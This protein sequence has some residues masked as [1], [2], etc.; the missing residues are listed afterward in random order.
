VALFYGWYTGS[1]KQDAA[2][3]TVSPPLRYAL[4]SSMTVDKLL[5]FIITMAL[6][7]YFFVALPRRAKRKYETI[8]RQNMDTLYTHLEVE[9]EEYQFFGRGHPYVWTKFPREEAE[10]IVVRS[11]RID[12]YPGAPFTLYGD[13]QQCLCVRN[14]LKH[15]YVVPRGESDTSS[16]LLHYQEWLDSHKEVSEN[17]A[18]YK[19]SS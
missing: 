4:V 2:M 16:D 12:T 3:R 5:A 13:P 1:T 9:P 10:N 7:Y 11:C 6:L 15:I 8:A 18:R 19:E 17:I 14:D